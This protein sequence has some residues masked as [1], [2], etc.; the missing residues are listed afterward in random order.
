MPVYSEEF[1]FEVDQVQIGVN[2]ADLTVRVIEYT[3]TT[4]CNAEDEETM[5]TVPLKAA[6]FKV[7]RQVVAAHSEVFA[8]MLKETFSRLRKASSSCIKIRSSLCRC[9]FVF[10]MHEVHQAY[11]DI[12][13]ADIWHMLAAG[14]KYLIDPQARPAIKFFAA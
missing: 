9:G 11:I 8:K 6:D 4:N 13:R 2:H 10:C 5:T 3:I 1:L 7:V 14:H 12:A